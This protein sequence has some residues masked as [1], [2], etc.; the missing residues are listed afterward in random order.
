MAAD[1]AVGAHEEI[2]DPF[3]FMLMAVCGWMNQQQLIAACLTRTRAGKCRISVEIDGRDEM[4]F[5]LLEARADTR[6]CRTRSR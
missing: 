1:P 5:K 2:L 6:T 4:G 3:R